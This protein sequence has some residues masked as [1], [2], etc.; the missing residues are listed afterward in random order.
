[1]ETVQL[2]L[3]KQFEGNVPGCTTHETLQSVQVLQYFI[4]IEFSFLHII[5]DWDKEAVFYIESLSICSLYDI[6]ELNDI[7]RLIDFER[8]LPLISWRAK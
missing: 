7:F 8:N 2:S 3:C 1:M 6:I 4:D 5:I